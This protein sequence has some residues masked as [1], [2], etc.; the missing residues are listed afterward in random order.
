M[1]VKIPVIKNRLLVLSTAIIDRG[2]GSF[3]VYQR[4]Y[5]NNDGKTDIKYSC[6]QE[7]SI[8]IF[9]SDFKQQRVQFTLCY[10]KF[11]LNQ[12]RKHK[13]LQNEKLL[14]GLRTRHIT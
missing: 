4:N 5:T 2:G 11:Q 12:Q 7:G 1:P 3:F 10:S 9:T 8:M 14:L 6:H 13:G